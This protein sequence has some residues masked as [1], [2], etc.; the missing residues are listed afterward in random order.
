MQ[1]KIA[2]NII[3][4]F[5]GVGKT[6]AILELLQRK[7]SSEKWAVLV[8][9]FGEV[10][11]D[12]AILSELVTSNETNSS[13]AT[14]ITISEV[15][16]GCLCCVSGIPFQAAL[17]TLIAQEKPDR[18]LIEP[19]GLGHPKNLI[20][21]LTSKEYAEYCELKA[22]VCLIDPRQLKDPRYQQHETFNDQCYLADV[23]VANKIDLSSE[24]DKLNFEQYANA[25]TP[26]KTALG[27]VE[28]AQLELSWL[29]LP[30]NGSRK[31]KGTDQQL[32]H[33]HTSHKSGAAQHGHSSNVSEAE[34]AL[35]PVCLAAN[36]PYQSFENHGM[37][38]YSLGWLFAED[39]VFNY[40]HLKQWLMMLDVERVKGL[41]ITN[42]GTYVMNLREHV[43]TEM[44]TRALKQSRLEIIHNEAL[45]KDD[46]EKRL[47]ACLMS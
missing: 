41:L 38:Y 15:P 22:S 36:T 21:N 24:Q 34:E 45:D 17:S 13:A 39:Q 1:K 14:G 19:T 31:V 5:L 42:T 25:I 32:A 47:M 40:D 18:I 43:F 46:L 9:E 8:N 23:L 2:V 12:G 30:R 10:G 33:F 6:T 26:K 3:M 4:G 35:K 27:W 29:D 20:R 28:N 16:G 44:P 7:P 11:I 37:G